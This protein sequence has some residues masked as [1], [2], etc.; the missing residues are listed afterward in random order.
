MSINVNFISSVSTTNPI[1]SVWTNADGSK[2]YY[3]D[4][5]QTNLY[6]YDQSTSSTT[7]YQFTNGLYIYEIVGGIT[8]NP[9]FIY[10]TAR[11]SSNKG[12]I[13]Y[14][15][16]SMFYNITTDS[17]SNFK[18][19]YGI[20]AY[21][22]N[23]ILVSYYDNTVISLLAY[24]TVTQ[25]FTIYSTNINLF[26]EFYILS[27]DGN[28]V[29]VSS[30]I[31]V[32]PSPSP[33][34]DSIYQFQNL[35]NTQTNQPIAFITFNLI[36]GSIYSD[37]FYLWVSTFNQILVYLVSTFSSTATPYATITNPNFTQS[38]PMFGISFYNSNNNFW[39]G[40]N[41]D[42]STF[43]VTYPV[44]CIPKG[45]KVLTPSGYQLVETLKDGDYILTS[46]QREVPIKVYST[47]I[48]K[49]TRKNAPY[50]IPANTFSENLPV[51]D[52]ILSPSHA[53]QVDENLW[54]IP[55]KA[56]K[57]Y[58]NIKRINLGKEIEYY[59]LETP[60]YLHDNLV[61]EGSVVESYGNNYI[62]KYLSGVKIY[63]YDPSAKA[64]RR[65]THK[66]EPEL[67]LSN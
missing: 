35:S 38:Y 13:Y 8:P 67:L 1:V 26:L 18:Y 50:L 19:P 60:N 52:I 10:L 12:Y 41:T 5:I 6:F 32:I 20:C 33:L 11:D 30:S 37:G 39:I 27:Y 3:V 16:G 62:K 9:D 17:I 14:F 24:D 55:R 25:K 42:I 51:N 56:I 4:N 2:V 43:S 28:Y 49:S 58:Q 54:Q 61:V 59:H 29:W 65:T 46:D 34:P 21:T 15:D 66:K 7:S 47:V 36:A 45:Q 23:Q 31:P 53:I 63:T 57:H 44:P 22:P 40:N 48:K 64:Y